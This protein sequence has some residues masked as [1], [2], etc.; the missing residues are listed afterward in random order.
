MRSI[1]GLATLVALA[2]CGSSTGPLAPVLTVRTDSTHY[3]AGDSASV[4]VISLADQPL[5]YGVCAI[6]LERFDSSGWALV[7]D[8]ARVCLASLAILGPGQTQV[9]RV[10]LPL[11]LDPGVYRLLLP[12]AYDTDGRTQLPD[13]LRASNPFKLQ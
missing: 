7:R 3:R 10:Y 1:L 11:G 12:V 2:A 6:G 8:S 5:S 4:R 13:D 9:Q